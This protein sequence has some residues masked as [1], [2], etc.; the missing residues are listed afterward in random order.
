MLTLTVFGIPELPIGL[1]RERN[2]F[3]MKDGKNIL[4]CEQLS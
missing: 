3:W 4:S 2:L 1:I